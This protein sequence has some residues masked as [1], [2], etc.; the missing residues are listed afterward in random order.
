MNFRIGSIPVRVNAAFAFIALFMAMNERDPRVIA[1]WVAIVFVSVMIHELGH[2]L[3]GKAFGLE[4]R[5]ELHGMGGTTSWTNNRDIGHAKRIAISLAG[6]FAGFTFGI[7]S[8]FLLRAAPEGPTVDTAKSFLLW[9]NVGW[10]IFNL[11]P[12]LPLDGGN[13]M[14]TLLDALTKGRGEKPARIISIAMC[15]VLG[16][17]AWSRSWLFMG[18]LAGMWG[19]ANVKALGTIEARRADLTLLP[20]LQQAQQALEAREGARAVD[21][22]KAAYTEQASPDLRAAAMQMIGYGLAIE[23]RW[24][25]LVPL[26]ERERE[27]F[28]KE[29]VDRLVE[30]LRSAG[31]ND[32]AQRLAVKA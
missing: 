8:L 1:L 10:G 18:I 6:P 23:G 5:I 29:D 19:F 32:D 20:A 31:R 27:S 7:V 21:L 24:D 3:T 2:A 16:I 12:L 26:I 15:A 17:F 4:P 9:V 28:A 25:E 22:V 30:A 11:L 13:V 14:K